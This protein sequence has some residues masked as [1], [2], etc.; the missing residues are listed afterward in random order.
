MWTVKLSDF[1]VLNT[2]LLFYFLTRGRRSLR[3]I[4]REAETVELRSANMKDD[5][6]LLL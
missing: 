4:K 1:T 3:R 6:E 5:L 2:A